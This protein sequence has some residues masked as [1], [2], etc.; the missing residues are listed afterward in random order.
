MHIVTWLSI[1]FWVGVSKI[2]IFWNT[3][4]QP[5]MMDCSSFLKWSCCT[6]PSPTP[7]LPQWRKRKWDHRPQTSSFVVIMTFWALRNLRGIPRLMGRRKQRCRKFQMFI[8]MTW[9]PD[10][11]NEAQLLP[12]C[13]SLSL[14]LCV[15]RKIR[16]AGRALDEPHNKRCRKGRSG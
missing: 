5:G 13:I 2:L 9:L 14:H 15:A 4:S 7:A 10:E 8:G 1:C 12:K 3:S 11:L 16:N 6:L